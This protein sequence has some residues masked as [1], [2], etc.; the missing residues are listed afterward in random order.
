MPVVLIAAPNVFMTCTRYGHLKCQATPLALILRGGAVG[1]LDP[2]RTPNR[3][4]YFRLLTLAVAVALG[5][6]ASLEWWLSGPAW[7][8]LVVVAV[9]AV[10][11]WIAGRAIFHRRM[12]KEK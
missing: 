2:V 11:G 9:S 10:I 3:A 5:L 4:R 6:I 1:D 8:V 12:F 7:R